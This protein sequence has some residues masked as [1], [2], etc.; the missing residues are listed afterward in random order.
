MKYPNIRAEM[1]KH[2]ITIRELAHNLNL[3]TSSVSFRLCGKRE[4]TLSEIEKIGNMF[5]CS[6]DYLVCHDIK[7]V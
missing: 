7:I 6:L 5:N 3:S 1:V 2:N 4:F